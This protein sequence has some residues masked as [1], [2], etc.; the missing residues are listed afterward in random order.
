MQVTTQK[1]AQ[2][3]I[4]EKAG[5]FIYGWVPYKNGIPDKD[6]TKE[7]HVLSS[8]S[9]GR[10]GRGFKC[11]GIPKGAVDHGES[12]F[13]AAIRETHEETGIDF[14]LLLGEEAISALMRGETI[15][16]IP[17]GYD[18]VRVVSAKPT[19]IKHEYMSGHGAKRTAEYY[20]IELDGIE[21]LKPFLKRMDA[22]ESDKYANVKKTTIQWMKEQNFP[23]F[24]QRL[25]MMRT[26]RVPP[27]GSVVVI[28]N[29]ALPT[30]EAKYPWFDITKVD[31]W[32]N[33]CSKVDGKEFKAIS[34]DV[35]K[36][37]A[38]FEEIG[39]V[40][41]DG[42]SAL[43]M[44]TKDTPLNF[45]QEGAEI[46]PLDVMLARSADAASKNEQYAKAMWG[47]YTGKRRESAD[48]NEKIRSAQIAPIMDFFSTISPMSIAASG[49]TK[50]GKKKE[51]EHPLT[52]AA[53]DAFVQ[54]VV[55]SELWRD[56]IMRSVGANQ[57]AR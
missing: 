21:H 13:D 52:L 23:S 4:P 28:E 1:N 26:G 15:S 38:Y 56:R 34:A 9:E 49:V 57:T 20:A 30:I 50:L 36:L 54:P 53:T 18:K 11:Y 22:R 42:E 45:Y 47:Q 32:I 41:H 10:F 44:D 51:K 25:S 7:L 33:F 46:I 8:Y 27:E 35:A 55:E 2:G 24:E 40:K 14:K 43:K 6:G 3:P 31:D 19:P 48:D 17:S 29:P 12:S 16:N 5:M 39:L 37:K